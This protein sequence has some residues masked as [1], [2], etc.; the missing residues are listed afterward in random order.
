M[1]ATP[2]TL[3]GD[4]DARLKK[5]CA[6]F[7]QAHVFV[8]GMMVKWKEGMQNCHFPRRHDSAIVIEVLDPPITDSTKDS[9][10]SLFKCPLDLIVGMLDDDGNFLTYYMDGRRF[11]PVV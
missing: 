6:N 10:S 1:V 8:P 2:E 4:S 5:L 11:E 7:S 3:N 9:G